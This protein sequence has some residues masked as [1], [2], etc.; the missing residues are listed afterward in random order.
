EGYSEAE[1]L[2]ALKAIAGKNRIFKSYIGMGYYDTYLPP[3]IQRNVLENPGWYTAYTPYQPEISQGRLEGLLSYQQ[4]IVDLSGLDM[5]NASLLDEATA[6]AEAMALSKRQMKKNK[7]DNFFVADDV[8]PQT[9]AVVKTR[10][11]HF[12]FNVIVGD[13]ESELDKHDY[14][15]ALLQ[16][17]GSTGKLRDL[18]PLIESIHKKDALA[19]VAADLM[20]LVLLTSPGEMGADIVVGSNQRFGVP[21]GFGGPH[22]G[23][24]AFRDE[25]KR[26]APGRI[27]GVSIDRTGKQALRMAMQTREQHIRRE[28]A[29]SNICTS[30]VLLALISAFY[31]MY[32][33]PKGLKEI[34]E[35]IHQRTRVLASS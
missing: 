32:H 16:Y 15:G 6:A 3:V 24:F 5:A 10:A 18:R 8:H 33:G 31:A 19:T 23:F 12:G 27:I 11:E 2:A 25:Y 30:Q 28:K 21:M 26:L 14:F 4:M 13:P 34:A 20:S 9:L 22:A 35:Q 7:S 29:T 1:A 17:P